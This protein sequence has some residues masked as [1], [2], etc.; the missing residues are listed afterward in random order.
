M[1]R[2]DDVPRSAL[3]RGSVWNGFDRIPA[4]DVDVDGD[5][6][7]KDRTLEIM[8]VVLVLG[9]AAQLVLRRRA[10]RRAD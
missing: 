10:R 5:V 4:F 6:D 8:G 3:G 9:L 1:R 2:S 7:A